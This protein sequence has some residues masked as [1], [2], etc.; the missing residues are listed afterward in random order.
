MPT[1]REFPFP[2]GPVHAYRRED[3]LAQFPNG[4]PRDSFANHTMRGLS[5]SQ[6]IPLRIFS[7]GPD[8][9]EDEANHTDGRDRNDPVVSL[10]ISPPT[11]YLPWG[12]YDPTNGMVSAGDLFVDIPIR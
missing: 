6:T 8:M 5:I 4:L 9:N 2:N 3:L 1:K 7:F 10:P 12:P 11:K